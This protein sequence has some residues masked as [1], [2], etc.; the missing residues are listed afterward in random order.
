MHG[1]KSTHTHTH[2]PLPP[3]YQRN[4]S[5]AYKRSRHFEQGHSTCP[6]HCTHANARCSMRMSGWPAAHSCA[7]LTSFSRF[8]RSRCCSSLASSRASRSSMAC[9]RF[10][11][12]V[13]G[14]IGLPVARDFDRAMRSW[15]EGRAPTGF[16]RTLASRSACW[17]CALPLVSLCAL[18]G[19]QPLCARARAQA[20]TNAALPCATYLLRQSW[21]CCGG[22]MQGHP[23][24]GLRM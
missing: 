19:P 16:L 13:C 5:N 14:R 12:C 1:S 21:P 4:T 17:G 15:M 2:T 22:S 23:I 10:C 8:S 3:K 20:R 6:T 11:S 9:C 24:T 7:S 18:H